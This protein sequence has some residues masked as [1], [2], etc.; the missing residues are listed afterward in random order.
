MFVCL[1]FSVVSVYIC[2]TTGCLGYESRVIG[3]SLIWAYSARAQPLCQVFRFY[4]ARDTIQ[5]QI[6]QN[7]LAVKNSKN[8]HKHAQNKHT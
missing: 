1:G 5:V 3:L 2:Q 6:T 8:K 7:M 4:P